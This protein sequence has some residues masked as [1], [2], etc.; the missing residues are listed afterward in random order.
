MEIQNQKHAIISRIS[1][2][3]KTDLNS[4]FPGD[5]FELGL[6]IPNCLL[7]YYPLLSQGPTNIDDLRDVDRAYKWLLLRFRA[8]LSGIILAGIRLTDEFFRQFKKFWGL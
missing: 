8:V 6:D 5:S 7:L 3:I 2:K 1:K 4:E